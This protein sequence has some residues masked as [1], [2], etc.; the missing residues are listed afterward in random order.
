MREG[1]ANN[2]AIG[3]KIT[4]SSKRAYIR[5]NK[6]KYGIY[7]SDIQVALVGN[8]SAQGNYSLIAMLLK[9]LDGR[10]I[11]KTQQNMLVLS[12]S[13]ANQCTH[14]N[15]NI[16]STNKEYWLGLVLK[17]DLVSSGSILINT[18]PDGDD[19]PYASDMLL[20]KDN[21]QSLTP[22]LVSEIHKI[23]NKDDTLYLVSDEECNVGITLKNQLNTLNITG[24][25]TQ[26]LLT[27]LNDLSAQDQKASLIKPIK[28]IV[29]FK[30]ILIALVICV[31]SYFGYQHYE[32]G[33]QDTLKK[34]RLSKLHAQRL[35]AEKKK[36][37]A[38]RDNF[39]LRLNTLNA[40]GV[41]KS[42][43]SI[44]AESTYLYHGWQLVSINFDSSDMS[45]IK[46]TY[47]RLGYGDIKGLIS[48][49][50]HSNATSQLEVGG[51]NNDGRF[52]V[53]FALPTKHN[54]LDETTFK[55][56]AKRLESKN[57][58]IAHLQQL[59]LKYS[60]TKSN[61]SDKTSFLSF[62]QSSKLN[63]AI[64]QIEVSGSSLQSL[65]LLQKSLRENPFMTAD[66]INIQFSPDTMTRIQHFT[67][68]GVLYA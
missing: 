38:I 4:S 14:T 60:I 12:Q 40:G 52:S 43:D 9:Y 26:A 3:L 53:N 46:L 66:S 33:R 45:N 37:T 23:L 22:L 2:Y 44:L 47:K 41:I 63:S 1:R 13:I 5:S 29:S 65:I 11:D 19:Q 25:E 58:L 10:S 17:G 64:Q 28:S 7:L 31:V 48:L 49:Y 27:Q 6:G 8:K 16:D 32:N 20:S 50:S 59:G 57:N 21:L 68:K 51:D 18:A 54:D 15:A 35:I 34:E 39:F 55:D 56:A 24:I 36:L 62:V 42:L 67:F 61:T 30:L